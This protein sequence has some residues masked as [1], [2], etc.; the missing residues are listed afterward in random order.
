[1]A[2]QSQGWSASVSVVEIA[3]LS[4]TLRAMCRFG[5]VVHYRARE[6]SRLRKQQLL[7]YQVERE[8]RT[9]YGDVQFFHGQCIQEHRHRQTRRSIYTLF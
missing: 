8:P 5:A 3:E 2:G 4:V 1:M 6:Q 9:H 7:A